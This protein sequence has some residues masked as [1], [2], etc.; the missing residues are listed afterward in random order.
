MKA[1]FLIKTDQHIILNSLEGVLRLC[2]D[3]KMLPW[4]ITK[5]A[6]FLDPAAVTRL[7]TGFS[8]EAF[9]KASVLMQ[10]IHFL[11]LKLNTV[12]FLVFAVYF[13]NLSACIQVTIP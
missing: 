5:C 8:K 11:A 1:I 4:Q 2:L 6:S 10:H 9:S 7:C 3:E 13:I 12:I